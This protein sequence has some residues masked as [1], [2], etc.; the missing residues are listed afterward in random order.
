MDKQI[1]ATEDVNSDCT[2]ASILDFQT[3]YANVTL[4]HM[5][6]FLFVWQNL[7]LDPKGKFISE[8]MAV[9]RLPMFAASI[10]DSI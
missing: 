5:L 7:K 2:L 3:L 10:L 6:Y 4:S 9:F 8:V 1:S